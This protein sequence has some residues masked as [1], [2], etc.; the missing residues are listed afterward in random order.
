M[1]NFLFVYTDLNLLPGLQSGVCA[2]LPGT[3]SMQLVQQAVLKGVA[4]SLSG[5]I[6][7]DLMCSHS[8]NFS[9]HSLHDCLVDSAS[10]NSAAN[11]ILFFKAKELFVD[12]K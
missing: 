5:I 4:A 12:V 7:A 2:Q 6:S 11:E 8:Q 10:E 3:S 9:A 1:S